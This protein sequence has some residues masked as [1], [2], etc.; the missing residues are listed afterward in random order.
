MKFQMPHSLRMSA[1]LLPLLV[2]SCVNILAQNG[3]AALQTAENRARFE[4]NCPQL[5]ATVISQKI[6]QGWRFEGS[7]HTIGIRGC[8]RQA[9]YVVYCRDPQDCNALSQTNQAI[10]KIPQP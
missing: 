1:V 10:T 8:D 2:T 4:M 6:I 9:V 5:Q 3:P 7:E